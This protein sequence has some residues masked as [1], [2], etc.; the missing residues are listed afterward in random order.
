MNV[1]VRFLTTTVWRGALPHTSAVDALCSAS[2][3]TGVSCVSSR[4]GKP[5]CSA[6]LSKRSVLCC[7][8]TR[9]EPAL[10]MAVES[11]QPPAVKLKILEALLWLHLP[12]QP[13][14]TPALL[15]AIVH[16]PSA[17]SLVPG[18]AVPVRLVELAGPFKRVHRFSFCSQSQRL[19]HLVQGTFH[20]CKLCRWRLPA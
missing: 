10:R 19:F 7:L 15:Q 5:A 1:C 12:Q 3:L 16:M 6:A 18:C 9:V 13:T 4:T 11:R 17:S 2:R 14:V 20:S 8:Q